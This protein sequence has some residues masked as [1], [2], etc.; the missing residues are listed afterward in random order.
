[1]HVPIFL[2]Q[3]KGFFESLFDIIAKVFDMVLKP[4]L[5]AT[6]MKLFE[7]VG[8]IFKKLIYDL[9]LSMYL[10]IIKIINWLSDIFDI[11]SG[12]RY[13]LIGSDKTR[14]YL[15]DYLIGQ[16]TIQ[17]AFLMI[18][19][20]AAALG[21][22]FTVYAVIKS[23][24][25]MTLDGKNPVGKVLGR[26]LKAGFTFMLIPVMMIVA[27]E[28]GNIVVVK[29]S[30]IITDSMGLGKGASAGTIIFLT[31]SLD[32]GKSGSSPGKF[33][34]TLRKEYLDGKKKLTNA[35]DVGRDFD[36][37]KIDYVT[38]IIVSIVM[39]FIMIGC[40]LLFIR[41]I[42]EVVILYLVSP[43][44]VA[45]MPLDDGAMFH[46]W[47]DMFVAKLISGYG[48]VFTMKLYLALVPIFIDGRIEFSGESVTDSILRLFI[49]IGGGWAAYKSQHAILQIINP[50][51][52][53]QAQQTTGMVI[54]MATG[55][56]AKGL[57]MAKAAGM[58]SDAMKNMNK[59]GG[60]IP[61]GGMSGGLPSG[62]GGGG[63]G[64][65]QAFRG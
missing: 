40:I 14:A 58:K 1:M 61:G 31:T 62:G 29:T 52:A 54:G 57:G 64:G 17:N 50:E 33:N 55:A 15:L 21:M 41:R 26:A 35:Y 24:S 3:S 12:T 39:I 36:S 34:D 7:I 27:L 2:A 32:A 42:F 47:R 43:F 46:K 16:S 20:V 10:V 63:S 38:G 48:P 44:F 4:I 19:L 51:M 45:T 8:G 28:L 6:T 5:K 23:I 59:P 11:F 30:N 60:G 37:T 49:I 9:I 53:S 65:G 56:A 22:L 13:M 18:T 25:D